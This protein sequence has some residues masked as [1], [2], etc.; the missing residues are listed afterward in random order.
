MKITVSAGGRFHAFRLAKQLRKAGYLDK[1]FTSFPWFSVKDEGLSPEEVECLPLKEIIERGFAKVPFLSKAMEIPYYTANLFDRQVSNRIRPCDI[2]FSWSGFSLFTLRKIRR[3]F[4]AK[5]IL[6]HTSNHPQGQ[7]KILLEEE[8][9]SGSRASQLS[10]S[11][12]KKILNEYAEA[13][14][15]IVPSALARKTFLERGFD[16]NK[17]IYVPLGVD[18]KIFR[19]A[20]KNDGVFRIIC[21]GISINKGIHYVL[22][23]IN[24]LKIDDLEVWLVGQ[25]DNDIKQFLKKYQGKFK[26]LGAIAQKELYKYYSQASIS[27]LF[28]LGEGFGLALLEA[29]ACGLAVICSDRVGAKDVVRE[30]VDGFVVPVRD[31]RALKEKILYFYNNPDICKEMGIKARKNVTDNF[32]WDDYGKKIISVYSGLLR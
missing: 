26:Y 16:E 24:E 10:S 11:F 2:F 27:I 6:E 3:A 8:R 21:I 30:G 19:P 20:P 29:M 4:P 9:I 28:S 31:V 12:V 23:A 7:C 22:R 13:D 17:V 5:I 15:I 25:I 14:Y 18:I 1:I 32:T